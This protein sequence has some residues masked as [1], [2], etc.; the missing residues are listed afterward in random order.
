M[1]NNT[2]KIVSMEA[3]RGGQG[4]QSAR[5]GIWKKI[6]ILKSF[7]LRPTYSSFRPWLASHPDKFS[8]GAHNNNARKDY[9]T[10]L[11][12]NENGFR[13]QQKQIWQKIRQQRN[14]VNKLVEANQ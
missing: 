4:G 3:R 12:K 11:Q 10:F 9:W 7:R 8:A 6:Q 14:E 13:G 5:F 1:H 2:T